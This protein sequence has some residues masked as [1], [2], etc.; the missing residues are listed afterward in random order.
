MTENLTNI[1]IN[2]Q[3]GQLNEYTERKKLSSDVSCM[4]LGSVATGEQRAWFLAVGLVDNT[5]RIISLDPA[6]SSTILHQIDFWIMNIQYD[7]KRTP[8]SLCDY[9]NPKMR[10]SQTNLT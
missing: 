6:V 5:V 3:T 9:N 2:L 8:L 10:Y 7:D 4:A 1:N